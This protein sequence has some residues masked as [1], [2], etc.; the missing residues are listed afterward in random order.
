MESIRQWF[1]DWSDACEYAK[2]CV[3]DVSFFLPREFFAQ[4][5]PFTAL[6]SIAAACFL[7]WAW[8]ERR[9]TKQHG[10][11]N[12]F[13]DAAETVRPAQF[14]LMLDQMRNADPAAQNTRPAP[15]E[16]AA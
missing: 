1:Q 9:I 6:A 10:L 2:E 13:R 16:K 8:N 3:P 12:A 14:E 5:E 11:E 4:H 15:A 7:I